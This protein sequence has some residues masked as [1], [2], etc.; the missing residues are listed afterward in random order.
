MLIDSKLNSLNLTSLKEPI[1][2]LNSQIQHHGVIL[3]LEEPDLKIV[4]VSRNAAS[5]LDVPLENLLE[6][7]LEDLLDPYK[8]GI[9]KSRLAEDSLDFINPTKI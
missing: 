9:I 2:N 7:N 6:I 4:Q 8:I 5:V 1:I 3:V